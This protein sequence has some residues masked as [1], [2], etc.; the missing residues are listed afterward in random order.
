MRHAVRGS[1]SFRRMSSD[2]KVLSSAK[3]IGLATILS[4]ITGMVRD[5]A[6]VIVF[7][8]NWVSDAYN[9][10]F[11]FPNLFRRLFAEGAMA[12]VFV[13]TFTQTLEREG[14][15]SAWRLL[16]RTIALLS[17][18]LICIVI[19]VEL[20]IAAIWWW[21]SQSPGSPEEARA[22]ALLLSLT[23]LMFPF[24]LT[25]CI[26]ALL[27]SILNCVG[28]FVPAAL[29]PMVTNVVMLLGILFLGPAIGRWGG[30]ASA[31]SA[32]F[33]TQPTSQAD[34]DRKSIEIY[35][36]AAS[37]L[38]AGVAQLLILWPV[39]RR[40]GIRIGWKLD[41][42]DATVRRM[43]G[44]MGPVIVGQGI[45]LIGV[46]MDAQVCT[47][48][49]RLKDAPAIGHLLGISYAYPLDEGAL[50]RLNLAQR[51]YQFPLGVLAISIATAAL[52]TLSRLAARE[53]WGEWK[54]QLQ[55]ALRMGVF[56]GLPSGAMML[57][58]PVPIMRLLFEYKHFTPQDSIWAGRVLACYG[59]GMWSFCVQ[60]IVLRGFY[61]IGDV[62]TPLRISCVFLP[63]NLILSL[64][65]IWF[66]PVREAAFGISTSL[67]ASLNV[68]T[69]VV[70]LQRK[71][72]MRLLDAPLL[73]GVGRM[74]VAVA[75][76]SVAVWPMRD[77]SPPAARGTTMAIA[78][79]AGAALGPLT[80]GCVVYLLAA[81]LLK[82][83]EPRLLMASR[84]KR[85]PAEKDVA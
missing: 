13:P 63:L 85:P 43:L 9:Y 14:R 71:K 10:A 7:G 36:V 35:G 18:T 81:A 54:T 30:P 3:L 46:F 64:I 15:E 19:A 59:L 6:L 12:A 75:I 44:L 72:G 62:A 29:M 53:D 70:I 21:K 34:I 38:V 67:T 33:A 32:P 66:P 5:Q 20:A 84:R 31:A 16:A 42:R 83:P 23:A 50:T 11:Q 22:R 51:L 28:S 25:I 55:A 76:A 40:H 27:S 8:A 24:M 17:V 57:A 82:L 49:T 37:V 61:S 52:P 41:L 79:R 80:V 1:L 78:W 47:L 56:V 2:H 74:L 77:F 73:A 45:L 60:H 4:R 48:F 58:L 26:L 68:L 69:G 39:V 65:L